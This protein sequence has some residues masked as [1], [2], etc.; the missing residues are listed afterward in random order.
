MARKPII[1]LSGKYNTMAAIIGAALLLSVLILMLLVRPAWSKLQELGQEIPV[2]QQKRDQ[3]KQDLENLES[4]KSFFDDQ[5]EQ[6][7]TINTAL[8]IQPD[9]PSILLILEGLA[10]D[11]GVQL[12]GFTPQQIADQAGVAQQQQSAP[13][14]VDSLEITANFSGRYPQLITFLYS[15]ERSL[16]I[17]D[18]KAINVNAIEGDSEDSV[19]TGNISFLAYYKTV[20][21]GPKPSSAGQDAAAQGQAGGA[22]GAAQAPPPGGGS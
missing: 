10:V 14:G 12:D 3:A 7:D 1:N 11:S 21:G 19:I 9:V 5:T 8:P 4:A 6:V 2:E 13:T 17:V 16:R 20:E 18:V 15:L 22:S